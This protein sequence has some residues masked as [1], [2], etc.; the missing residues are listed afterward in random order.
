MIRA[1]AGL[2]EELQLAVLPVRTLNDH[3]L[4]VVEVHQARTGVG[5]KQA[6]ELHQRDRQ[7]IQVLVLVAAVGERAIVP[8]VASPA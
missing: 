7:L 8:R 2:V 5:R 3:A 4:E 6:A 1:G